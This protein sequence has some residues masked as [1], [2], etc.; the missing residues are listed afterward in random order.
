MGR[1]AFPPDFLWE[2][3]L[4]SG[5]RDGE[6]ARARM[7]CLLVTYMMDSSRIWMGAYHVRGRERGVS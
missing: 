6:D 2:A 4:A 3:C 1:T 7:A 5:W